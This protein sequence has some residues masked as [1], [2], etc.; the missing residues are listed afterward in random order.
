MATQ[1]ALG[2]SRVA[3]TNGSDRAIGSRRSFHRNDRPELQVVDQQLHRSRSESAAEDHSIDVHRGG[4]NRHSLAGSQQTQFVVDRLVR[5]LALQLLPL[6][7]RVVGIAGNDIAERRAGFGIRQSSKAELQRQ[8]RARLI[9][10]DP[11]TGD[12]FIENSRGRDRMLEPQRHVVAKDLQSKELG[13]HAVSGIASPFVNHQLRVSLATSRLPT[14]AG[15]VEI[16]LELLGTNDF[17]AAPNGHQRGNP[18][19]S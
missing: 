6:A 18:E 9:R 15:T 14:D 3:G 19:P 2:G 11:E 7:R 4:I 13:P 5:G 1:R 8:H 12:E 17:A 10:T 16:G